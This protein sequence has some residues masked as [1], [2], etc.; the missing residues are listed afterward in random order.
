MYFEARDRGHRSGKRNPVYNHYP[1]DAYL[2]APAPRGESLETTSWITL[3][4]H[5]SLN[6]VSLARLKSN[7]LFFILIKSL[8]FQNK[9][10]SSVLSWGCHIF[11]YLIRKF[12]PRNIWIE[13]L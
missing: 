13:R 5:K 6:V 10:S 9:Y 4:L 2:W 12:K 8:S 7:F 3:N 11:G 1:V